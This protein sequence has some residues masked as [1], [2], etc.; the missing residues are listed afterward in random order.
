MIDMLSILHELSAAARAVTLGA[1]TPEADNKAGDQDFDP[2]TELDRGAERAL[3]AV[4]EQRFPE[5]GIEGEEY[6][7]SR[8]TA[9]RRWLLDP[10]DGTRALICNLPSWTTLVALVEDG[11]PTYGFIDAPALDELVIGLPSGTSLNGKPMHA[12]GCTDLLKARLST[13]DP[14][15]FAEEQQA[16]FERVRKLARVTRY[17]L[18]ALAYARL[19]SGHIDLVIENSLKP[20]DWAALVPVV[21]GA[22]G[23]IGNWLGGN[24]LTAGNVVAAATRE[25]FDQAIDLLQA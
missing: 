2:V 11:T 17:G 21:R 4:L 7:I 12:S 23:T 18:D 8:P 3:R 20:H 24:D 6:G 25:L 15:L 16:A 14:F 9:R 19:A 1:P 5:D 10:V 13:T 22:G